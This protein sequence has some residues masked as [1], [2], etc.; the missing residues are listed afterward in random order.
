MHL[1]GTYGLRSGDLDFH[2]LAQ[3]QA[4][5]SQMVTGFKSDLLKLVDPFFRKNGVT[6]LPIKIT[7]TREHPSFGLDFHRKKE[8]AGKQPPDQAQ[9]REETR[10]NK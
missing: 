2:G 3:L 7:G 9:N 1:D 5:P 6:Q 10:N 4:K 8:E